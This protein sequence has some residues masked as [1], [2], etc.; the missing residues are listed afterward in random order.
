[1]VLLAHG[2]GGFVAQT[3]ARRHPDCVRGLI[4]CGSAPA[5]DYPEA[6]LAGAHA[7][8]TPAQMVALMACITRP[9]A[10][11]LDLRTLWRQALPLY[12]YRFTPDQGA[13]LADGIRYSAPAYNRG[14]FELMPA[15]DSQPWLEQLR[16]PCLIAAGVHDWMAPRA[17]ATDRLHQA[18]AQSQVALFEHSGHYPFIEETTAFCHTVRQ[19]LRGI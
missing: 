11:D 15:F 12:F 17:Q 5:F 13:A 18:I 14:L 7:Q 10:S 3:L 8:A 6:M 16:V 4:L 19:F 1:V 9:M 2:F